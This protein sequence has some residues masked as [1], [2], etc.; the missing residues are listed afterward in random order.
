[1]PGDTG[2]ADIELD[3]ARMEMRGSGEIPQDRRITDDEAAAWLK[4]RGIA[5][6]F[7]AQPV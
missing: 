4:M 3:M 2:Y 7:G 5:G 1:M 6:Q